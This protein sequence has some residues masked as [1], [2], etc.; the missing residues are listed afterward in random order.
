MMWL[1][2]AVVITVCLSAAY[3]FWKGIV[4][5]IVGVAGLLG[6][7]AIAG[8]FYQPLAQKLWPDGGALTHA[9]A[10]AIILIAVLMAA[11]ILASLLARLVHMTPL[12]IVDRS[13]GL[14][15][16]LLVALLGWALLLSVVLSAMP[17]TD[18]ALSDSAVAH[19]LIRWLATVRGLP[20][21]SG[22]VA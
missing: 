19:A 12:G 11:A 4:R 15:V 3:G 22:S 6:G 8:A 9:T 21:P 17:G 2:F 1:D 14:A 5:A 7:I 16:G 18:T 10:Y 13:L 20:P